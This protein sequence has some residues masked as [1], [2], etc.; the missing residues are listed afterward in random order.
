MPLHLLIEEIRTFLQ[1]K[2]NKG[3]CREFQAQNP[4]DWPLAGPRDIVLLPDLA[5]E[6]GHPDDASLSFL[7]WTN[8]T[9]KVIS[10]RITLIGPDVGEGHQ[11]RLPFGKVV[12]VKTDPCD[13]EFIYD[14]YRD[15]DLTR[16]D[17]SLKGYMLRA[18][19][20][21][22]REWSRISREAVQNGFSLSILGSALIKALKELPYVQEAE[23]IFITRSNEDVNALNEQG[24]KANRLILAMNKMIREMEEDC[25]SCEFQDVCS[26]ASEMQAL[27]KTLNEKRNRERKQDH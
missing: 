14:R 8:E 26:D 5:V 19:S 27:K 25:G 20:Q 2:K 1:S 22:M 21:Y 7:V 17:L 18:T 10:D 6:L 3:L 16:F 24:H 4:V 12:L 9:N 13:E 23:V 11:P 15:M